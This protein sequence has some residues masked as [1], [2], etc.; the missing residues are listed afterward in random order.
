MIRS[1]SLAV[2]ML[3]ARREGKKAYNALGGM[4]L[5]GVNCKERV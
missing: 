5:A 4:N 1:H 2:V 3:D